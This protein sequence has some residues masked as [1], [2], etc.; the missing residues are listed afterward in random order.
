MDIVASLYERNNLTEIVKEAAKNIFIPLTVGGG[1]R[2]I[3]DID[4]I[5]RAGADKVA[6]N[7]A[8]TKT[9]ELI[10]KAAK[11]FGSQCIVG[12][13]EAKRQNDGTWEAYTD[14]GRIRTGLDAIGWAK[15]LADLGAGELLVTSVDNEGTASGYDFDLIRKIAPHVPVPVIASGGAGKIKDFS[16]CVLESKA[17]AVSCAHLLHYNETT[18]AQ[19]KKHLAEERIGVRQTYG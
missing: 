18:I 14:N 12:S 11:R 10:T 13:I 17:D 1:I 2:K 15:R 19:I 8:A 4:A 5:L 9:P 7:T 3:E 6:I 16:R